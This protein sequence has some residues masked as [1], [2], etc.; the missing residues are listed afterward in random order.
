MVGHH[1]VHQESF[2]VL[3]AI[4]AEEE[5]IDPRAKFPKREIRWSKERATGMVVCVIDSTEQARLRKCKFKCAKFS[6][7]QANDGGCL[8][9][10][11]ND[12]IHTMNNSIGA[13]LDLS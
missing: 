3:L 7:K 5:G 10:G 1:V 12:A 2:E 9:R 4:F 11:D 8:W 13:E 6:R